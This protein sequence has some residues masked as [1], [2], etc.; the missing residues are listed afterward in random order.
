MSATEA[1]DPT[2]QVQTT[3]E[4]PPEGSNSSGEEVEEQEGGNSMSEEVTYYN[5]RRDKHYFRGLL[6]VRYVQRVR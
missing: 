5:C 4:D 6:L 3:A 1:T 2:E